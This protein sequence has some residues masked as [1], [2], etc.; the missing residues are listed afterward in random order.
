VLDHRPGG[1]LDRRQRAGGPGGQP[2]GGGTDSTGSLTIAGSM[3]ESIAGTGSL[4]LNSSGVLTL[5]GTGS[6][7]GGT[8]VTAG[9]LNVTSMTALMPDSTPRW[10]RAASWYS[11]AA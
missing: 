11:A 5:A 6:Y 4:T 7:T 3:S 9:T 2:D 8:L 1:A 10:I